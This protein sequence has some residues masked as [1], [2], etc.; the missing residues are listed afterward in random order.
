MRKL[1]GFFAAGLISLS[2]IAQTQL[3]PTIEPAFFAAD[4]EITITYD[5]TETPLNSFND[6]WLWLWVPNLNDLDVASNVNPA[7]S[8]TSATDPAK[9]TKSVVEGRTYFS[10]SLTPTTFTG[11]SAEEIE[12]IGVLLKGNDWADGQT[13]D[14]IADVTNGFTVV[15][16][17]PSGRYGFYE[18]A[19]TITINATASATSDIEIFVDQVSMLSQTSVSSVSTMHTII[20]DGM[21][22]EIEVVATN[23]EEI[24]SDSYTYTITPTPIQ[25]S[26]PAGNED[27]INIT[28][29][30][31]TTLVLS[32]PN[33]QHVFVIGDFN[34]WSINQN[35]LMK[36]D[37]DRFWLTIDGLSNTEE[38]IFQYLV[39]G[40]LRIADPYATKISSQW[41]DGQIIDE[42]RY[43]GLQSYPSAETSETASY[44]SLDVD[45]FVWDS[46][47]KPEKE[48]LIIYELLVR[49]FT[50]ERTFTAVI[51]RLDYLEELG[52]NALELM[53][54]MEFEGNQSWGY[55][56][57]F[58]F[59][60]DKYYGTEHQL[61]TL[62]NE[63]HKRGIAVILDI[64]LNH[65]FGRNSLVRLYNEG[66]YGNP[67][68]DNPWF[69]TSAKHD[70]N[71]GYDFN[72]ESLLT[73]AYV[74]RV[75]KFWIE[76]YNIDGYRFDLSKGFTQK[77][78]LGNVGAWGN[79]DASRV[80]LL[81]RMADK[82]W[83][84]DPNSYVIL[85]HF[86]D[87]SEEEELADYGMMLWGNMNHTY[88][89][90]SKGNSTTLGGMYHGNRG[91]TNPHLVGYMESH[92][93][94]RV[95]WDLDRTGYTLGAAM[96]RA[97][98]AAAFMLLVPGPKLIWQFG[99]M[100]YDE[101]LNN[102]RLGIK[103][104]HWEYL[105]D[106][107]RA[108]VFD[109][110]KSLI[111]LRTK[112]N[113]VDDQHFSWSTSGWIKWIAIDNPDV[114]I[115]VVGNFSTS[116]Q[117]GEFAFPSTGTWFDYFSGVPLAVE[118]TNQSLTLGP[119]D[120]KIYTSQVIENYVGDNP[121]ITSTW[122]VE[123]LGIYPNPVSSN[124]SIL[125]ISENEYY[126][127]L[128]LQGRKHMAGFLEEESLDV[129]RLDHGI[130]FLQLG[131]DQGLKTLRF[132]K[133]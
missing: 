71:V 115:H 48:D 132:Y 10:I 74:D 118:S 121:L 65:H 103:P 59:A 127:V 131:S 111:N 91:W 1:L 55:N 116:E 58:K 23:G 84:V 9:F 19:E 93:E 47:V 124:L 8:N 92:D 94:E 63:C 50:D 6:A 122:G 38:Y 104:T 99:E 2:S 12:S 51:D 80:S 77:N 86:A 79:Y 73:Q 41:D 45:D 95:A 106:P 7:S 96:E 22:H 62:V 97:K 31:S 110:Y 21:V 33:K 24:A 120:L 13:S 17:N 76:E 83:E 109:L 28:S 75:N 108:K 119:G 66:L 68:A 123:E 78:T 25:E 61:K 130:Y 72:H 37:G 64:V 129:S 87:N 60:V 82:I 44:L 133:N 81:K 26:I 113:Y 107:S 46:F 11:R 52:I 15:L 85:E 102:D 90:A 101:E 114:K 128:D 98:L 53:P 32:A 100:G 35:F 112:T 117:T 69:N 16:Q 20:D 39:D 14:F 105:D 4:E 29:E 54:V 57:A 42:N 18:T 56:P 30:T 67:T 126:E 88:R 43:P 3:D 36:K 70:F 27:G 89:A 5:V 125:G 49:D 40:E 34:D